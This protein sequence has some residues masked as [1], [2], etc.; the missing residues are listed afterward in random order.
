MTAGPDVS[1]GVTLP[2]FVAFPGLELKQHRGPHVT[3]SL[4]KTLT[5]VS[6]P[7]ALFLRLFGSGQN[8]VILITQCLRDWLGNELRGS[9]MR[10]CSGPF[11]LL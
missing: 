2:G 11:F 7:E 1:H 3:S 4:T 6:R 8:L 10:L 5:L 9:P